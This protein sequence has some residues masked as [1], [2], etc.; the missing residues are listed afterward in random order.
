[1]ESLEVIRAERFNRSRIRVATVGLVILY[2]GFGLALRYPVDDP[3]VPVS[4]DEHHYLTQALSLDIDGDLVVV[5][6]YERGDYLAYY[7]NRLDPG[8]WNLIG[9][10]GYS[11]HSPGTGVAVFPGLLFASWVG[12][13]ATLSIAMGA[14]F[15]ITATTLVRLRGGPLSRSGLL[16]LAAGFLMLPL[17]P[18]SHTVYPET[19]MAF[20]VAVIALLAV[21]HFQTTNPWRR[22]AAAW[23]AVSVAGLAIALHPK[24]L[25]ILLGVA[26]FFTVFEC[27]DSA[28][29]RGHARFVIASSYVVLAGVW[30]AVF[31]WIHRNMWNE[32]HPAG[33]W[34]RVRSAVGVGPG[35]AIVQFADLFFGRDHGLFVLAPLTLLSLSFLLMFLRRSSLERRVGILLVVLV[36]A[37]VGLAAFSQDWH[38][39]DSPLG[40]YAAPLVPVLLLTSVHSALQRNWTTGRRLYLAVVV[41]IGMIHG[42]TYAAL[43]MSFRPRADG[44][45]GT[46]AIVSDR[47]PALTDIDSLFWSA[48]QGSSWVGLVIWIAVL[49]ATLGLF[50]RRERMPSRRS[51]ELPERHDVAPWVDPSTAESR[52][53]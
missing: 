18:Y 17:L 30:M 47:V 38:G 20:L 7:G 32:F 26:I 14:T 43:P 9:E 13:L 49:A 50:G 6:N 5:N 4:G 51:P 22:A 15:A 37:I 41:G 42:L 1:M 46:L 53:A 52:P 45:S 29:R 34:L 11:G 27:Y 36:G 2:L 48:S 12:V 40:R 44:V 25:A 31:S 23:A 19:F 10:N 24:Y 35:R 3:R 8:L 28:R 39:G 16:L 21:I 33:W